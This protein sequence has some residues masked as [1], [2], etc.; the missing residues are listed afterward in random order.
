VPEG[1]V[2]WYCRAPQVVRASHCLSEVA[3][4]AVVWYS[5]VRSHAVSGVH[6]R[7]EMELAALD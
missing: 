5:A 6:T 2:D 7:S 1:R 4:A 3:V